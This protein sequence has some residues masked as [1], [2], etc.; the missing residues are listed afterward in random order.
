MVDHLRDHYRASERH[1]CQVL[2]MVRGTYRYHSHPEP[3]T[4]L[5]MRIREMLAGEQMADIAT[6]LIDMG[7]RPEENSRLRWEWISWVN[8]HCGTL[9]VSHGKTTAARRMLP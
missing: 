9:Q 1:A 3:W 4:E 5:R 8:G 7:M 2:L 6:V